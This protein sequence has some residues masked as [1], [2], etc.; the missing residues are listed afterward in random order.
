MSNEFLATI[1]MP[2]LAQRD[3]WLR[4]AVV[5]A[6]RQTVPCA[7]LVITSP[8][9]P[10]SNLQVLAELAKSEPALQVI[11]RPAGAAFAGAINHGFRLAPTGRVGLLLT[12]DWLEPTTVARCLPFEADIVA[13]ARV[14]HDASGEQVLWRTAS[15]P[16]R[17]ARLTSDQ[18][19]ASYIDHFMLLNREAVLAVGG[20][21]PDIGLTG[22]DDYDLPWMML[23]QGAT[24]HLVNE[25]LYHARDHNEV[26]LT[27]RDRE[28]QV[29]DL[30]RLLAKHR[31]DP[32]E[33]ERLVAAKQKW[34]GVPVHVAIANPGWFQQQPAQVEEAGE[35]PR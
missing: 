25:E 17:Y 31:V 10:P 22:A 27:L 18:Q 13:T 19:R 28:A 1:V 12:D 5:S 32:D 11:E 35:T 29:A 3:D 24:V 2:L 8:R 34:Y 23:E 33:I 14:G 26:R 15:D 6:L 21:D 30:R 7:V 4:Q 9:T 20:V 16:A